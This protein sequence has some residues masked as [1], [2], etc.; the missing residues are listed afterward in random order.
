M[1]TEDGHTTE[2]TVPAGQVREWVSDR[3]FSVRVGNAAG[4]T[5][6][7]NGQKLP[8]LGSSGEV[9]NLVLPPVSP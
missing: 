5:L 4:V 8:A 1:R 6:E 7:L 2:E 3:R 9:T